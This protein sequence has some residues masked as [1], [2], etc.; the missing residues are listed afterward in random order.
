[1]TKTEIL[2]DIEYVKTLAEQG[3]NAP[4]LAGRITLLWGV[5]LTIALPTHWA[6]LTG[7]IGIPVENVG[8]IWMAFG[9][10]GGIISF[11]LG[12][13]ISQKPGSAAV[14]NRVET[15]AWINS[16]ILLFVYALSI[17]ASIGIGKNTPLL[18]DTIPAVA[19]GCQ[20]INHS[21]IAKMSG[22][23]WLHYV[24]FIA[25]AFVPICMVL[26]GQPALYLVATLGV[27]I[28]LIIPAFINLRREPQ[29]VI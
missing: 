19:F 3:R 11:W 25:L 6:A 18:F 4:L 29:D 15:S 26:L 8:I 20:F 27:V 7:H 5:L 16:N 13:Q 1:M 10:V 22:Q 17:A 12:R 21:V 2:D 28:T 14:G 23:Y 24:G 9:V